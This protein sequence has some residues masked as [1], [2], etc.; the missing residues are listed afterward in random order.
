[1]CCCTELWTG[2]FLYTDLLQ[3]IQMDIQGLA[4]SVGNLLLQHNKACCAVDNTYEKVFV[5][6]ALPS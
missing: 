2:T 3:F 4:C 6:P 1:M 5:L